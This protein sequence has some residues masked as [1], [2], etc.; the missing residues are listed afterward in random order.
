MLKLSTAGE[1]ALP[2]KM[3]CGERDR[4]GGRGRIGV[5][6][7]RVAVEP[8]RGPAVAAGGVGESPAALGVRGPTLTP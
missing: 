3:Q 8:A 2:R 4:D 1:G 5:V 7:A 6:E